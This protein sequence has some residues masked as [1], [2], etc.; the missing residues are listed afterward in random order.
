MN[1]WDADI[2]FPLDA[3]REL[4]RT[5]F[6]K[7][8][9]VSFKLL[10]SGWDNDAYLADEKVVFRFPRRKVAADLIERE[11]RALP[12]IEHYVSLPISISRYVGTPTEDYSY[13][14][15]GYDFMEGS[16]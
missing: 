5:Q 15:A 11:I 16:T 2:N 10:S 14:W 4:V 1:P 13:T 12:L 8:C 6:P 7:K 3:A 9:L